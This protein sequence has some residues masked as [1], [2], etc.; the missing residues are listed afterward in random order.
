MA[1]VWV[2]RKKGE[3]KTREWQVGS[4]AKTHKKA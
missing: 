1:V 2:E 3:A 4:A